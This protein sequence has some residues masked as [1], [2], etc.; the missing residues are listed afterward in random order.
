MWTPWP[1]VAT[2]RAIGSMNVPT[3]SPGNRGYDVV[4]I[5]T[6]CGMA[7]AARPSQLQPPRHEHRLEN[8]VRR[9]FRLSLAAFDE[10]DRHLGDAAAVAR[11]VEEHLHQERIAVR[12]HRVEW[13]PLERF[14]SPAAESARAVGRRKARDRTDVAVR[15]GAQKDAV[16]GPVHDAHAVQITR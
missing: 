5:T 6:T 11:G 1:R 7:S 4:T 3:L 12:H 2:E 10:D 9:H 16:Q 8:H 15:E 14:P 13:Q